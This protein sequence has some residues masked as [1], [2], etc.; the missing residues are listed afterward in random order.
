MKIED[1]L[2]MSRFES[3]QQKAYLNILFTASWL[4]LKLLP[5][6]RQYGLSHE[7][8]NVL[9]IL[10][11]QHPNALCLREIT[12]RMIDKNSNTSRIVDKLLEK[13]LVERRQ[14]SEDRREISVAITA[15][16]SGILAA[17]QVDF[18]SGEPLY[19]TISDAEASVVNALLDKVR[20]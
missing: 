17:I 11:G 3:E 7:Q 15:M 12:C 18:A 14:S 13:K 1:E 4:K 20:E 8:F 19:P 16:G 6:L 10:E 2:K 9:R 5:R